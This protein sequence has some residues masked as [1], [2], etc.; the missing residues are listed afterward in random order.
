MGLTVYFNGFPAHHIPLGCGRQAVAV[1]A[2][3]TG[4]VT[5][6]HPL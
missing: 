6:L 2:V 4:G 1:K 3:A 5:R